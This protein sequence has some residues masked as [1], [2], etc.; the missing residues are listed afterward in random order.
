M[1]ET[2]HNDYANI[3]TVTLMKLASAL[4]PPP[5]ATGVT[6]M[7]LVMTL[8]RLHNE[9]TLKTAGSRKQRRTQSHNTGIPAADSFQLTVGNY[10]QTLQKI[11]SLVVFFLL[12][13]YVKF[14]ISCCPK[15][16]TKCVRP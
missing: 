11:F 7:E 12:P 2:K 6:S 1:E 13:V 9:E 4:T 15:P 3:I 5:A 14:C 10:V 16:Q 8:T